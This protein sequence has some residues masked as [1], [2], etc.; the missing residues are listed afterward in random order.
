MP[1]LSGAAT[2]QSADVL[3]GTAVAGGSP[4]EPRT[5]CQMPYSSNAAS[6][7]LWLYRVPP[8]IDP[9]PRALADLAAASAVP[10]TTSIHQCTSPSS[11][12]PRATVC[13]STAPAPSHPIRP[14]PIHHMPHRHDSVPQSHTHSKTEHLS[15]H[16]RTT[17][18]T[19][20]G[21]L[22]R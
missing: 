10:I 11:L 5:F 21:S 13:S 17:S 19:M 16:V 1:F 3:S 14:Q 22:W 20:H 9:L 6:P 7:P 4:A 8:L 18:I 15:A 2:V 12:V